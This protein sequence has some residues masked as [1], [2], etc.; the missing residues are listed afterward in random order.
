[1]CSGE[2]TVSEGTATAGRS[3]RRTGASTATVTAVPTETAPA[4]TLDGIVREIAPEESSGTEGW[5]MEKL[6]SILSVP[7]TKDSVPTLTGIDK[8]FYKR[9]FLLDVD[10]DAYREAWRYYKDNAPGPTPD[11]FVLL[12]LRILEHDMPRMYRKVSFVPLI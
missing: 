7:K 12:V 11:G 6:R 8:G 3:R 2:G 10:G 9:Y 4:A 1:M 5:D